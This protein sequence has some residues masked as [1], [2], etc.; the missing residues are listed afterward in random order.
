MDLVTYSD[1]R[2][3]LRG[4]MLSVNHAETWEI[5]SPSFSRF[6]T[7]PNTFDEVYWETYWDIVHQPDQMAL[8]VIKKIDDERQ[9]NE[10]RLTADQKRIIEK[11]KAERVV[12]EK[13]QE[14]LK[15]RKRIIIIE[16]PTQSPLSYHPESTFSQEDDNHKMRSTKSPTHSPP[17]KRRK[18]DK[19]PSPPQSTQQS[20]EIPRKQMLHPRPVRLISFFPVFL[21]AD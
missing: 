3:H 20:S 1:I 14:E 12:A 2:A 15:Q 10:N 6:P 4:K 21:S 19:P 13:K 8:A 7:V 16:S 5:A 9:Q 18:I 11:E 17:S